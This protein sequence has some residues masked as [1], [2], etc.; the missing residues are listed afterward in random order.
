MNEFQPLSDDQLINNLTSLVRD[1][2]RRL[3]ILLECLKEVDC[4]KLYLQLGYSSLFSYMTEELK[5]SPASAQRR[6]D[7][8]RL[9]KDIPE[10]KTEIASGN[11]Q[12][13]QIGI[14]SQGIKEKQKA[15][16][17]KIAV[18]QK[19]DLLESVKNKTVHES[20]QQVAQILNLEIK[21]YEKSRMQ[22]DESV[23]LEITLT[24]KQYQRLQRVKELVSGSRGILNTAELIDFLAAEF[25]KKKDPKAPTASVKA[26]TP[27]SVS[28]STLF[29]DS[30]L[31][32]CSN[33]TSTS[34]SAAEVRNPSTENPCHTGETSH[35]FRKLISIKTRREIFQ[36]DRCCQ[37]KDPLTQKICGTKLNLQIDHIIP[38]WAGGT[39]NTKNLQVLCAAHNRI[40]YQKEAGIRTIS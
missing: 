2:R 30:N 35:N 26:A 24:R 14:V 1:E 16:G 6:I 13:T 15:T 27:T 4:R 8:A 31:I 33:S 39:N 5:Y 36:R 38:V 10:I 22:K 21:A 37:H 12:L 25:I 18:Y 29:D 32:S 3:A 40:K 19:K 34:T 23:R 28:D 7:A 17:L 11:L 9:L 20:Q